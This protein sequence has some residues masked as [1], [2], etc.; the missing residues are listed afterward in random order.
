MTPREANVL[1]TQAALLDG[2]LRREPEERAQMASAWAQVLGDVPLQPALEALTM[3]YREQT[4]SVMPADIAALVDELSV[5]D[6]AAVDGR[7]WLTARGINP[8]EFEQRISAGERPTRALREL[9]TG[10]GS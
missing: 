3:H 6:S 7:A 1:L 2:R 4:R 8:D 10:D 5:N 9:G